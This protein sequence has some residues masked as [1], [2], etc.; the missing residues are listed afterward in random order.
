MYQPPANST[1]LKYWVQSPGYGY[2]PGSVQV[3]I[4]GPAVVIEGMKVVTGVVVTSWVVVSAVVIMMVVINVVEEIVVGVVVGQVPS[5]H[6][7]ETWL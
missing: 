7:L 3:G 6:N 4:S 5:T 2:T 1:H